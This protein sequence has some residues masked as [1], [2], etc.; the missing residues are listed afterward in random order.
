[1]DSNLEP[2]EVLSTTDKAFIGSAK[3][4]PKATS[5]TITGPAELTVAEG[6][7]LHRRLSARR[8]KK[9][10]LNS[11]LRKPAATPSKPWA[12]QMSSCRFSDRTARPHRSRRTTT[13]A[14]TRTLESQRISCPVL[15]LSRCVTTIRQAALARIASECPSL[16]PGRPQWPVAPERSLREKRANNSA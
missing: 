9:T 13:A 16:P 12:K 4:Y 14:K 6:K 15:T 1:M 3:G 2:N 5:P 8:E 7:H 10:S 11:P